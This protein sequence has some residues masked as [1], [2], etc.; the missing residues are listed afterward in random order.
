MYKRQTETSVN[1]CVI[2]E[3]EGSFGADVVSGNVGGSSRGS[4]RVEDACTETFIGNACCLLFA[5]E[6]RLFVV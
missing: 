1:G 2:G 5:L 4:V 3:T 6:M